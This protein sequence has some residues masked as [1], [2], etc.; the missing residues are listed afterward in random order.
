[1]IAKTKT[2]AASAARLFVLDASG[3]RILSMNVDGSD[4]RVIVTGCRMPD[5]VA[6]DPDAGHLYWTNMG[7]PNRNDGSL[8]RADIDGQHRTTI[9]PEGATFTPKQLHL[10]RTNRKLYWCDREGMRVMRANLRLRDRDARGFEPRRH[11]SGT[12]SNEMVRRHHRRCRARTRLLDAKGSGQ[13]R[14][15]SD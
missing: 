14:A 11:A 5:G 15:G 12:R 1:M 10:D 8:E 7:V 3:G 4:R 13:R 9:V 6:V 2:Q